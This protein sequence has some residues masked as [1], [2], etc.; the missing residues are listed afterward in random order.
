MIYFCYIYDIN[1]IF[2]CYY[3]NK[4]YKIILASIVF[5]T[6]YFGKTLAPYITKKIAEFNLNF[7]ITV[8]LI[9]SSAAALLI[10]ALIIYNKD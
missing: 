3:V 9:F 5:A 7:S 2:N 1:Y 6:A 10:I 4:F 8:A